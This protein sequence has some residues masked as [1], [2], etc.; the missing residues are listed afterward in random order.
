M[1]LPSA[2]TATLR[3]KNDGSDSRIDTDYRSYCQG[4]E[5]A[6]DSR[7]IQGSKLGVVPLVKPPY[8]ELVAM[9]LNKGESAWRVPFGEGS[10]ALRRSPLLKGITLPDRLGTPGNPGVLVTKGGVIFGGTSDFHFYA[11]DKHPAES[12]GERE[13]RS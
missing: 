4:M 3:D 9:N 7:N 5:R 1:G 13:R 12:S 10:S 11:F 2:A 6:G 8:A